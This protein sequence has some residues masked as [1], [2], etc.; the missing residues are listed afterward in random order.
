MTD[1]VGTR[2]LAQLVE[3]VADRVGDILRL[4]ATDTGTTNTFVDKLNIPFGQHNFT[5]SQML[6]TSGDYI[7]TAV[8]ITNTDNKEH[9]LTFEPAKA[10]NI[11]SG[12]TAFLVNLKGVGF[13]LLDYRAAINEAIMDVEG[14]ARPLIEYEGT[15]SFSSESPSFSIPSTINEVSRVYYIDAEGLEF[16]I[17]NATES[18]YAGWQVDLADNTIVINGHWADR[19]DG[20]AVEII[21]EGRYP[22]LSTWS[23]TTILDSSYLIPAAAWRLAAKGLKNDPTG[24]FAR[25]VLPFQQEAGATMTSVRDRRR[26]SSRQVRQ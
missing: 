23:A 21:G 2:T 11:A 10:G 15:A 16:T 18:G 26:P 8:M 14:L 19:A 5:R 6:I 17:P 24:M 3:S 7:N 1:A 4:E 9:K 25:M 20:Y 12:T 22:T 13:P